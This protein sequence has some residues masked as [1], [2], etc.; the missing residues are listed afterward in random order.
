MNRK[1]VNYALFAIIAVIA[2]SI[3]VSIVTAQDDPADCPPPTV[4]EA[5]Y[6]FAQAGITSFGH[7]DV[8]TVEWYWTHP[9][10]GTPVVKYT[11]E[12]QNVPAPGDTNTL[13]YPGLTNMDDLYGYASTPYPVFGEQQRIR[14]KGIDAD[15]REGPWSIWSGW[16]GDDGPPTQPGQPEGHMVMESGQ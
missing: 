1:F 16:F 8:P 14:V 15:D 6:T 12:M 4:L 3:W 2:V 9:T 13:T 11:L 5:T 7:A 10:G